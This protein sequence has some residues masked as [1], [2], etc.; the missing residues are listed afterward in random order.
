M[1]PARRG[2]HGRRGPAGAKEEAPGRGAS[3]CPAASSQRPPTRRPRTAHGQA[4]PSPPANRSG[5]GRRAPDTPP[6]A[7][8][9]GLRLGWGLPRQRCFSPPPSSR[10]KK[11]AAGFALL[12]RPTPR[13]L[14]LSLLLRAATPAQRPYSSSEPHAS[15]SPTVLLRPPQFPSEP[16]SSPQSPTVLLGAPQFPSE[17]HRSPRSPTVPLRAPPFPSELHRSPQSSHTSSE[18]PHISSQL[19]TPF[20]SPPLLKALTLP[21]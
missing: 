12:Q 8:L 1:L 14:R 13:R 3:S 10:P 21:P 17:L 16:H 18:T 2:A 15:E 11:G 9:K 4:P 19:P 6:P 7:P 5:P 20:Q